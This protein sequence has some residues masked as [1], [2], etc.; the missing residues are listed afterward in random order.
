MFL[1]VSHLMYFDTVCPEVK[2]RLEGMQ[3]VKGYQPCY[4]LYV[5]KCY[6]AHKTFLIWNRRVNTEIS[7]SKFSLIVSRPPYA[8]DSLLVQIVAL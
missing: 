3:E 2:G 8:A 5:E 6:E 4:L 7:Q 1:P